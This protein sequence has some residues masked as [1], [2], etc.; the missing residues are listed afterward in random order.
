MRIIREVLFRRMRAANNR[1]FKLRISSFLFFYTV[2]LWY[3][4]YPRAIIEITRRKPAIL[5]GM[6]YRYGP[7]LSKIT[8][9]KLRSRARV[10]LREEG[11]IKSSRHFSNALESVWKG[12]SN[13]G[14]W[15]TIPEK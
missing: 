6:N 8:L 9:R 11:A 7:I 5:A 4:L 14:A 3:T 13:G 15:I 10:P 2:Y 1:F 12:I